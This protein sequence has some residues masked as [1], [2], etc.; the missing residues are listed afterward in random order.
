MHRWSIKTKILS[1]SLLPALGMSTLIAILLDTTPTTDRILPALLVAVLTGAAWLAL[2]VAIN[3]NL[4]QP[5]EDCSLTLKALKE[6]HFKRVQLP[7][8]PELATLQQTI[9]G[10]AESLS[11]A[12][13][14]MQ[15]NIDRATSDLRET[16]KTIEVQNVELDRVRQGAL[17]DSRVKS[18]FIANMS[19]EIRT[20]LNAIIGFTKLLSK[21]PM[22][23]SQ[24]DQITTILR[25][26]GILLTIINDVLDFSK[27]E[28]NKLEL[29]N[30][31]VNLN[32]IVEDVL[33][34]LAPSAHE[35]NLELA[36]LVYADVPT[37]IM[38][39]PLRYKQ[40]LT[41]LVSNGIKFSQQ[42]E[43]VVR[44]MLAC[45]EDDKVWVKI[46]VSDTGVGLSR[47]QQ[48]SL[49]SA[50]TQ[51]DASTA[52][53]HGGTGLGLVI[54]RR[55][56]EQMGGKIGV[57]S[58]LGRG[59]EFWLLM[60]AE[61][62]MNSDVRV[63]EFIPPIAG[64]RFVYLESQPTI[65]LAIAHILKK[66]QARVDYAETMEQV[67]QAVAD[68]QQQNQGYA[69][70]LVG[71]ESKHL[72]SA[73]LL[74]LVRQLE[75]Q[76]DCRTLLLTPTIDPAAEEL[77]LL[78]EASGHLVK[79]PS[80]GRLAKMLTQ[81]VTGSY[82]EEQRRKTDRFIAKSNPASKPRILAVDDNEANLK[83]ISAFLASPDVRIDTASS[84]YEAI[85][86]VVQ[87]DYDIIFMDLQMPAMDGTT[88][89]AKIR[90]MEGASATA[91]IAL[92]A[93][94]LTEEKQQLPANGFDAYLTKPTNEKELL[95]VIAEHTG[96]YLSP[97]TEHDP[98]A[99]T[100][101]TTTVA[102]DAPD[103]QA[104]VDIGAS[105]KLAGNKAD[106]A[107]ELF[108]MLTEDLPAERRLIESAYRHADSDQLLETVHKLHG[109][110]RYC[111]VPLLRSAVASVELHIKQD[112]PQLEQSFPIL[113]KAIDAVL[114]WA[115]EQSWREEFSSYYPAQS[116]QTHL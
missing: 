17:E 24:R 68:A 56:T 114:K 96:F 36:G 83:L 99:T 32:E 3:R 109:A 4:I 21:T 86:M 9:N 46:T 110:T 70:A 34:M 7:A 50:F 84:G 89:T 58:K 87:Q 27:I 6:G 78:H 33:T 48:E 81:L 63:A 79:P 73:R 14:E 28:A 11:H 35:K 106:L 107:E 116:N 13:N 88:T 91:I 22:N 37:W 92:T 113:L 31:P 102:L 101:G 94:A 52:R 45:N 82:P 104:C 66:W 98:V 72:G 16:L 71:I 95:S 67:V 57:A 97:G 103:R 40:I 54:S 69:V 77:N 26:A 80:Q 51:A 5:L 105:V 112:S 64:E 65:R 20:P 55:L 30:V 23:V 60:P 44:V 49:F 61:E 10:L 41:N 25:S 53:Q 39:D 18:E 47:S 59:S 1:L 76:S 8:I 108:A 90:S 19:H 111:G 115:D 29:D 62:P 100:F 43:V 93:H 75:Y 2:A 38:G 74:Q 85:Q 12:H 42:G 15:E